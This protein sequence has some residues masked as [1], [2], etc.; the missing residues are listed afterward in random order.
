MQIVE[1]EAVYTDGYQNTFNCSPK[2]ELE[3]RFIYVEKE[4]ER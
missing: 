2:R 3:G 4:T 1:V